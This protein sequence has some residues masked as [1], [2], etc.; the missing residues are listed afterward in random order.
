MTGMNY[1]EIVYRV[2][3]SHR[4]W[5]VSELLERFGV[6]E[7]T[8]RNYRQTLQQQ[9]LPFIQGGKSTLEEVREGD[10]RY[11]RLVTP[12]D[13]PSAAEVV[14]SAA[15]LRLARKVIGVLKRPELL[16]ALDRAQQALGRKGSKLGSLTRDLDR[17]LYFVP[18]APKDYSAHGEVL[19]ALLEALVDH[20]RVRLDYETASGDSKQHELEP[21]T[22]ALY[23]GGLHLFARYPGSERVYNFVVDRVVEA[24][25]LDE[26]F[27]Y[28]DDYDPAEVL[29]SSFG[30]FVQ[31]PP[32]TTHTVELV[33]ADKPWLQRYLL[34]RRWHPTQSFREQPDG[35][36]KL[37]FKVGTLAEVAPWVRSFGE[38]V[39]VLG[40]PE[41]AGGS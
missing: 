19:Q 34:E 29:Q 16:S 32:R 28:P 39:E 20:R 38:E 10:E 15:A 25:V 30:I 8:Y 21:L 14:A 7:R 35:R 40:P 2:V 22:L 17:V 9:F 26:R 13:E 12:D 11:L 3:T 37:T 31:H 23:R 24:T 33:F 36:L 6:A 41:L 27:R 4:G 18:D 5:R 1:A